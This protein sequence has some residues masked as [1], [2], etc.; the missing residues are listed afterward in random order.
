MFSH[1]CIFV[2]LSL[3]FVNAEYTQFNWRS[4]TT[5]TAHQALKVYSASAHPMPV[6]TP[7]N[8]HLSFN[9]AVLQQIEPG[10]ALQFE[11]T[12]HTSLGVDVHIPCVGGLGSC[13]L[14][15]CSIVDNLVNGTREGQRDLGRQLKKMFESVGIFTQCPIAVQNITISDYTIHIGELD[16]ALNLFADGDYTIQATVLQP[17]TGIQLGCFSFDA[18]LKRKTTGHSGGWLLGRRRRSN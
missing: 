15:G 18:T 13:I 6:L 2:C 17:S 12:R 1:I 10:A 3:C 11:I 4:C 7:G 9:A 14:D 5:D 8:L 16:P